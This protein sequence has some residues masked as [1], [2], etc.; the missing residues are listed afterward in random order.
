MAE[1]AQAA[2]ESVL[3][4][5]VGLCDREARHG[6]VSLRLHAPLALLSLS[7]I[8]ALV[9]TQ[10]HHAPS[11]STQVNGLFRYFDC[12]GY[13]PFKNATNMHEST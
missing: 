12:E 6:A 2:G 3:R 9:R 7:H 13:R 11:C 10:Y 1:A 4:S 8:E 5:R